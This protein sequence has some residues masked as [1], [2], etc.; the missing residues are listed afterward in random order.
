M[1]NS[2]K[3]LDTKTKRISLRMQVALGVALPVLIVL[4]SFSIWHYQR[5]YE[6]LERQNEVMAVKLGE[7]VIYSLQ[8]AMQTKHREHI[9]G[10]LSDI[11]Q[12]ND[13]QLIQIIGVDGTVLASSQEDIQTR[14]FDTTELGC[15]ECHQ[16]SSDTR[17]RA[18]ELIGTSNLLRVSAPIQNQ[19][20]C[21]Q[22]HD[23][24][25]THLGVLLVDISLT[26]F[27][28][29]ILKDIKMDFLVSLS[30]TMIIVLGVY[31]MM[32]ILV[33][34]RI[35]KFRQ[36]IT[37]FAS[38][39]FST[40]IPMTARIK[41]ELCELAESFNQMADRQEI[42]TKEQKQNRKVKQT[43]IIEERERLARELHDGLAQILGYINTEIMTIRLLL[44]KQK[45]EKANQHL[46]ELEESSRDLFVD[47]REVI[48]GLKMTGQNGNLVLLLE[49][50]ISQFSRLS[51][52]KIDFESSLVGEGLL[53][54]PEKEL[55]LLRIVQEAL[56]NVRKHADATL[57]K[58]ILNSHDHMLDLI[59]KDNGKGIDRGE[60]S[61][62]G[63]TKFGIAMMHERAEAVGADF[64]LDSELNLGTQITVRMHIDEE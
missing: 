58:V 48:L 55:H 29:H 49:N 62:E 1:Q 31:F 41:D 38:G 60:E 15:V 33:V 17:P 21:R 19:S 56:S 7:S 5:E 13:I 18:S 63:F 3:E 23:E 26:D 57:V 51:K 42:F 27:R 12:M 53:L 37:E 10:I 34:R 20:D 45:I 61:F 36:P 35:E 4:I 11:Q 25:Q 64:Q 24:E 40:R 22:C 59:I 8:H 43:A 47:V 14:I 6:L 30:S 50:Y 54:P 39:T 28:D 2:S 32:N 52:L 44:N 9:A 46:L 16:T